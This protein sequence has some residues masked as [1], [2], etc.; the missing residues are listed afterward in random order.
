MARNGVAIAASRLDALARLEAAMRDRAGPFPTARL[1]AVG[2]VE[3]W[4]RAMP[5]VEAE[6]RLAAAL[7]RS[8]ARDAETG[9]AGEGPHRSDLAVRHGGTGAPAA[10]CSTG[11]QKALLVAILLADARGKADGPLGP[12][13]L[14]L[15]EV[16]A[17][18]DSR[19]RAAL[20]DELAGLGAQAWL[21]GTDRASFGPLLGRAR[22]LEVTPGH[23]AE[24]RG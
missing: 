10:L 13:I 5:A 7:A 24:A 4:V 1:D 21:S 15:D 8:R 20:Y 22:F 12:P 18:L 14:L 17:H 19:R 11:E 16:A 3:A 2:S 6:E 9:G 23:V